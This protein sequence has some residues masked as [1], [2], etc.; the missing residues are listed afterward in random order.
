VSLEVRALS[1]GHGARLLHRELSFV[2][3]PRGRLAIDGPS[4]V[5]KTSLLRVLAWLDPPR[6]GTVTWAGRS[7]REHGV[8]HWRRQ[9][10]Y[11]AQRPTFFGDR[12][13]EELARPT[14]YAAHGRRFDPD[15]ARQALDAVDLPM[16]LAVPAEELSEGER[17]R[18]ALVRAALLAPEVLLLDEPTSALDA[19][20][21]A[22]V[23]AWLGT[24]PA[25]LVLVSHDPGLRERVAGDALLSLEPAGD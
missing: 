18:A 1:V 23:E 10:V 22:R 5:G 12:L 24:L 20:S 13:G 21:T 19:V 25:A 7:P 2:L 9:V 4:G 3:P 11:V 17:Q 8:P 6:G 15:R 14:R 16:D